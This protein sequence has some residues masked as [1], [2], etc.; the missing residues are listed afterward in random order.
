V[1]DYQ[2]TSQV[3]EA[4]HRLT[5]SY[6]AIGAAD[7]ARRVAAVLGYNYPS[8]EWYVDSYELVTN[9]TV[10]RSGRPRQAQPGFWQRAI[11]WVF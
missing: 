8:S 4:L 3:P 5:E 7:E 6:S 10:D 1:K 9:Q 11:D 2:T